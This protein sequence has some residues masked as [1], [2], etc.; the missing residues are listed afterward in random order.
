[1]FTLAARVRLQAGPSAWMVVGR[2]LL[3]SL[4]LLALGAGVWGGLLRAGAAWPL[5]WGPWVPQA[6]SFH[7][8][9][10]LC[11]GMGSLIA[12]ERAVAV[13]RRWAFAAPV[14]SGLAG[15]LI[16][17][18]DPQAAAGFACMAALLLVAVHAEVLRRQ[19]AVHTGLLLVAALAWTVGNGLWA[20]GAEL[21][22]VL[23]WWFVLP[24]LTIAAER[25]E[26][27][28]LRRRHALAEPLLLGVVAALLGG[29][30][31]NTLAAGPADAA[32]HLLAAPPAWRA[33]GGVLFGSALV[34]L[35]LWCAMFDIARRTV[36]ADGLPRYMAVCLLTAYAWLAVAGAAWVGTA[37]GCPG[38]DLALH[39]LG[40][41]FIA[42]MVMAH[43]PV[44]LPAVARIKLLYGPWFY[45]P[46]VL[47]N[48]SLLLR[49]AGGWARPGWLTA[50]A[51]G[52]ALALAAF[53]LTL[54]GAAWAWRRR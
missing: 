36:L 22:A 16:L 11:A 4:V 50:G 48:G 34:G 13:K 19:R 7:A 38:R 31:M 12:I 33:A 42:S 23:P 15:V 20:L 51:E 44:V 21:A 41:G 39:A 53:G 47:L 3:A 28:R 26:M 49:F 43:A 52:N 18:G 54:L 25:L 1:M 10:M 40:L 46:L 45:G 6:A 14:A 37:L 30:A 9:L 27:T 29:A 5:A 17:L 2:P 8:A 24:V 32:W 35:A